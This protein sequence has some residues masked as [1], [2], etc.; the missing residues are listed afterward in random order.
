MNQCYIIDT[1]HIALLRGGHMQ[2]MYAHCYNDN[3][4]TDQCNANAS[5]TLVGIYQMGR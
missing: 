5:R 1:V 3:D 2:E 4:Q